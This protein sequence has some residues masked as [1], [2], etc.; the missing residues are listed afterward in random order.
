M[1]DKSSYVAALCL[2]LKQQ[3]SFLPNNEIGTIYFGG[4]TPSLLSKVELE[5]IFR[6][7]HQYYQIAENAEITLESNPD[8]L[9]LSYL[10]DLLS[11]GFNRLS[12]GIQSFNDQDL[13][14]IG[15]RHLGQDA[16]DV[17]KK[18]QAAGFKNISADLIFGLPFQTLEKWQ[19]NLNQLF[20]LNVQHISCYNLSYETGTAFHKMLQKGEL[21]ELDDELSLEMYKML[22]EQSHNKGFIHYETSNFALAGHYSQHN[23]NYWTGNAY[24]G[25]GAGAHAYNGQ[26]LRRWNVSDNAQYIKGINNNK[27]IFEE[28]IIDQRTAYNEFIM[29]GLRTIWGCALPQLQKRFGKVHLDYCLAA[30][31]PYIAQQQIIIKNDLLTIAPEAIFISDQIISDLMLVK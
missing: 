6:T 27:P 1:D 7:I 17:V 20:E 8:D 24:L 29:T 30:A 16:I 10:Q 3:V 23:S 12:V 28:E 5:K 11:L 14:L 21:Q 31:A 4:G 25:V 18:A 13:Q 15:R 9:N 19:K 22:I 2:E 26:D